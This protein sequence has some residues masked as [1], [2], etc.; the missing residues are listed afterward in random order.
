MKKKDP[1]Q[2]LRGSYSTPWKI[3]EFLTVWAIIS[4]NDRVLEPS[5]GEGVFLEAAYHR[6]RNLGTEVSGI[7]MRVIGVEI[8]KIDCDKA[9][10]TLKS[11]LSGFMKENVKKTG[12]GQLT[13]TQIESPSPNILNTDFFEFYKENSQAKFDV[14]IGNP[15][16][17]RYQN[18]KQD[19]RSLAFDIVQS[20]GLKPNRLTN[21]WL[22]FVLASSLMLKP[23]GRLAMVVPAELLQVK[24]SAQLRLFL[25]NFFEAITVLTFKKLIFPE[26]QEEVVLL[27]AEKSAPEGNGIGMIELDDEA[28]LSGLYP[29]NSKIALKPV[30]HTT[31]KWTQYFLTAKEILFL[32]KMKQDLRLKRFGD[33]AKVD[34]GVV[35]G[36]N[37]FFVVD[38]NILRE[39]DLS[40]Y[41]IPIIGR[42][43]YL[44]GTTFGPDD[45]NRI[46]LLGTRCH[47]LALPE[48]PITSAASGLLRYLEK[49]KEMNVHEGYKCRIRK[50]WY[51]VPSIWIPDAFLFRQINLHPRLV[52]NDTKATVTDTIHR[53]KF[54][55]ETDPRTAVVCFHNSL[56]F[57]FS[58]VLGR[59]YGG[60]VL[61]LEPNEAEEV[62]I[63]YF[64]V[65]IVFNE[66][67]RCLRENEI[68]VALEIVDGL[69]LKEHLG[70]STEQV[71]TLRGV[72]RKLSR[73]RTQRRRAS[74]LDG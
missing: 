16:F 72:W 32:R 57:A 20:A 6:L 53:V 30:E 23:H 65:K 67:D 39:F 59:S 28:S 40:R 17:I 50:S 44:E 52:L 31:D 69:V 43:A 51:S 22:P 60:G 10:K 38:A 54:K 9:E 18:W 34:V 19:S 5:C 45:L 29:L 33:I 70:L 62:P 12:S 42:T 64:D 11:T 37:Q 36:E 15:P 25:S 66:V 27:L 49:G 8:E 63:P 71:E 55:S 13:L 73:R 14:V 26:I 61:E 58:E 3:A 21:A 7:P 35:T 56:T 47:L 41:T 1:L 46:E 2:K 74:N 68:D 48:E 24:Y 4:P